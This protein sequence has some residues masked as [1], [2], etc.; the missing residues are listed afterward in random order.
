MPNP[1]MGYR[2]TVRQAFLPDNA[3]GLAALA[4]I[5]RCFMRGLCFRVDTSVT[6]GVSNTTVWGTPHQ[7]TSLSGGTSAHGWPDDTYFERLKAECA[8]VGIMGA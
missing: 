7:K 2:G 3:E 4:M 5:E 1:G 8:A 6:T